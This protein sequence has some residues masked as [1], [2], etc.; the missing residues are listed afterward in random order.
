MQQTQSGLTQATGDGRITQPRTEAFYAFSPRPALFKIR[1]SGPEATT[2][3]TPMVKIVQLGEGISAIPPTMKPIRAKVI[4]A[5]AEGEEPC[6]IFVPFLACVL[7]LGH[8]D[9]IQA[10]V[11][12]IEGLLGAIWLAH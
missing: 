8:S 11:G 10:L 7:I 5:Q 2:K 12:E 4:E 1:A 9:G 3:T 6:D